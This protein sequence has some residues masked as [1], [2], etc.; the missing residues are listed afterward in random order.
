MLVI[1]EMVSVVE[2]VFTTCLYWKMLNV[3]MDSRLWQEN[4]QLTISSS[5]SLSASFFFLCVFFSNTQRW[6]LSDGGWLT[7][8]EGVVPPPFIALCYWIEHHDPPWPHVWK[9]FSQF[10]ISNLAAVLLQRKII[11]SSCLYRPCQ[12]CCQTPTV[13]WGEGWGDAIIRRWA[14]GLLPVT[15]CYFSPPSNLWYFLSFL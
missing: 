2:K 3:Q 5:P 1:A 6:W 8:G 14:E 11:I 7:E 10:W 4:V 9:N 13:G 15:I 12:A